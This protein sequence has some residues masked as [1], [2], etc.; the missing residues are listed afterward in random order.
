MR[1]RGTARLLGTALVQADQQRGSRRDHQ[2]ADVRPMPKQLSMAQRPHRRWFLL[3]YTRI[4]PRSRTPPPT[5]YCH[6]NYYF[7]RIFPFQTRRLS[8][9]RSLSRYFPPSIPPPYS[10]PSSTPP[11]PSPSA[12][13]P[14]D[15]CNFCFTLFSF[16]FFLSLC[17][18]VGIQCIDIM[19]A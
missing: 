1:G 13:Y 16:C 7:N 5:A 15:Y 3:S 19:N 10:L 8:L 2:P 4:V 6:H 11:L 14:R 17:P 12:S 18:T 9:S